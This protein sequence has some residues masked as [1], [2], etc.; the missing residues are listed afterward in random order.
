MKEKKR[1]SQLNV[2]IKKCYG[3]VSYS[4]WFP[5]ASNRKHF[6]RSVLFKS[7][8]ILGK[9]LNSAALLG[10]TYPE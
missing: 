8:N 5:Y 7:S 4:Q 1:L 9:S 6:Y 3:S 10:I 2:H